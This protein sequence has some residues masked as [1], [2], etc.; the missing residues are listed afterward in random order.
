MKKKLRRPPEAQN[1]KANP[2]K[3][4]KNTECLSPTQDPEGQD[5]LA[6]STSWILILALTQNS[7]ET[8]GK[9]L[10]LQLQL[11]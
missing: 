11:P 4:T 2:N 7:S 10:D 6:N 1:P 3:A 9:L 5:R 8:F